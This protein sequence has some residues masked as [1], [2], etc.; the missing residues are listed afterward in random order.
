MLTKEWVTSTANPKVP[1]FDLQLTSVNS[2]TKDQINIRRGRAQLYIN[3]S[4]NPK[5]YALGL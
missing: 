2:S 4:V 1:V 3:K 5:P